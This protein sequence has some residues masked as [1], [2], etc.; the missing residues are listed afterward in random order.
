MSNKPTKTQEEL[1]ALITEWLKSRPECGSVTGVAVAPMV[2]IS[3]DRP[4]WHAAFTTAEGNAVPP[5]TALELV[6]KMTAK[7]DLACTVRGRA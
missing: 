1:A 4:N 6:D 2:R 7:F 3:D 5:E